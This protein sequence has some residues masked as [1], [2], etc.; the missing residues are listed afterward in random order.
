MTTHDKTFNPLRNASQ[1]IE[2]IAA[3]TS[4]PLDQVEARLR[5]EFAKPGSSVGNAVAAAN[6]TPHVWSEAL[7]KFYSDSDAFVYELAVWSRNLH[8]RR[9]Q[10]WIVNHL[11]RQGPQSVLSFGDGLGFDSLELSRNGHRVT[12]FE[13]PGFSERFARL[14]FEKSSAAIEVCSDTQSLSPA[15]FDVVVCLDVLEHV[16][17]PV[18]FVGFLKTFL[19]PS[20]RLIVH[21]PFWLIHPAYA[22]HLWV[23]KKHA[24]S[25]EL[26]KSNGLQLIDAR[27]SWEPLVFSAASQK[28]GPAALSGINYL[29]VKVVGLVLSMARITPAP[30]R[31]LHKIR[32]ARN[33][34]F[35]SGSKSR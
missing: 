26:Y 3:A 10:K 13:L 15:N 6:I 8:K 24:G 34:W 5:S 7:E 33:R 35:E 16:P 32:V 21:S 9:M 4:Q 14:L 17:D 30:F 20:G 25:L 31:P 2:L 11:S 28:Q 23:N 29:A 12:Y 18:G 27:P 1:M 22:T 19:K